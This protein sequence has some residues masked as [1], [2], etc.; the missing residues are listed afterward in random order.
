MACR[1]MDHVVETPGGPNPI[2]MGCPTVLFGP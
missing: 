2:V 1:V